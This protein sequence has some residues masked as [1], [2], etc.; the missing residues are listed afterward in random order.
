MGRAVYEAGVPTVLCWASRVEDRAARL[1]AKAFFEMAAAAHDYRT[2]FE[3]AKAAVQL[4]TRPGESG[5]VCGSVPR[6][7][8]RVPGT[9]S[10]WRCTPTPIAAGVPVLITSD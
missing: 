8:L 1:F 2:C 4:V 9:A 5:G 10:A 6:Y 7:E 3:G